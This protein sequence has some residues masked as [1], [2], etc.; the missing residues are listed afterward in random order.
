MLGA[1][2]FS[3]LG[4]HLVRGMIGAFVVARLGEYSPR[5]L[6]G[7][8]IERLVAGQKEL[9]K[10]KDNLN[11]ERSMKFALMT[12]FFDPSLV[13]RDPWGGETCRV[14]SRKAPFSSLWLLEHE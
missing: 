7:D 10:R 8:Q 9:A 5:L 2:R 4:L 13:D 6:L 14:Q 11:G 3:R 1:P 12:I